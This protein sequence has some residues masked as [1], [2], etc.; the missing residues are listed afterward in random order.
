MTC[1]QC[2][3]HG[4]TGFSQ[5]VDV[6]VDIVIDGGCTCISNCPIVRDIYFSTHGSDFMD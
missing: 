1:E 4:M 5:L 3:C 2:V 6:D